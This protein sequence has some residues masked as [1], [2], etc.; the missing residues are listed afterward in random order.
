MPVSQAISCV[1]QLLKVDLSA[2]CA[3]ALKSSE[4]LVETAESLRQQ[5]NSHH[6]RTLFLGALE[7]IKTGVTQVCSVSMIGRALCM[8]VIL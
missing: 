7:G 4:Q 5:P 3:G 2:A 1:L 8:Q 6:V